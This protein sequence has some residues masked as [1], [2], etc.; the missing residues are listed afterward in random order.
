[1]AKKKLPKYI[2]EKCKRLE[3]LCAEANV[4]RIE[5]ERWCVEHGADIWSEEWREQVQNKYDGCQFCY[6]VEEMERML[7]EEN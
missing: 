6:D 4:L 3:I 2:K 7:Y 5:V 1:M